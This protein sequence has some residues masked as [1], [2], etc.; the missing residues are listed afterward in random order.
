[1][2]LTGRNQAW[3]SDI[4]YIH[5]DEGFIYLALIS[6]MWSRKIVGYHAGNTLEAAASLAAG[7]T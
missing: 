1:M 5:T 4:T 6:D 2:V 7:M 3:A